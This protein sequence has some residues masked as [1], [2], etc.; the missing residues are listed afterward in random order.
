MAHTGLRSSWLSCRGHRSPSWGGGTR[1]EREGGLPHTSR[2]SDMRDYT[3]IVK[4]RSAMLGQRLLPGML[5]ACLPHRSYEVAMSFPSLSCRGPSDLI[6]ASQQVPRPD[7]CIQIGFFL[8]LQ[9][10]QLINCAKFEPGHY[11]WG[12]F[13]FVACVSTR[14]FGDVKTRTAAS[15]ANVRHDFRFTKL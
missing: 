8:S 14:A 9:A 6:S 11:N 5:V 2:S 4:H 12:C 15:L 7:A 1:P 10:P 3:M 13:D